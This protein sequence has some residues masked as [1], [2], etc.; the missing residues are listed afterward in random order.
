MHLCNLQGGQIPGKIYHYSATNKPILFVLDGTEEEKKAIYDFFSKYNRYQFC[1]NNIN[2]IR[3][4]IKEILEKKN[5]ISAKPVEAFE[6]QNVVK[7]ILN[8]ESI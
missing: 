1:E 5:Q 7:M 2:D 6:P 8:E 3:A 4:A